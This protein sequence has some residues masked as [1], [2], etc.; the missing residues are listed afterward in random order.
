MLMNQPT[1][2]K[3]QLRQKFEPTSTTYSYGRFF[4]KKYVE[5]VGPFHVL[6]NFLII[7]AARSGTTSLYQ[8][9]V[10]HPNIE[11]AVVKQLHFF[12]QYFDRG[13]NWYRAN[14]PT[15]LKK[16]TN[17]KI[18]KIKFLTG[19]ATPY[20]L[21]NPNTP[22]RVFEIN[23]KMKLVL[24][25]RNPVDRAFSHYKRKSK[26][27]SEKLSFE[28]A[29][30]QECSRINGEI[31]KMEK[32]EN[33]FSHIYHSLS[34]IHAGLYVIHLKRW[35]QF[36]PMDQILILENEEFLNQTSKLY[37]Q[38]LKFLDLPDFNLSNYTKFQ[39][40][41]PM[42][43]NVQTREK[44]LNYCK[45]YNEELFSLIGKKFDWNK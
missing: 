43:M 6:P 45:P 40:S 10:Q 14:F 24:V 21:Q 20:Y 19:E 36:F 30:K 8:Y 33:Y 22:K 39:E 11:P 42:E 13:I 27:G 35:L 17:E 28:E 18:K 38:T 16:F 5:L 2:F 4:Y 34:Y 31:E 7:G 12:D 44:L 25:L 37:S 9:L 3:K 1:R 26:N 29:T 15:F 23:P 41:K 32:N